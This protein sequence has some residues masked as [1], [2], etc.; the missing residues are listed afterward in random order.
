[1]KARILV[2]ENGAWNI[3]RDGIIKLPFTGNLCCFRSSLV[4]RLL[5]RHVL[6]LLLLKLLKYLIHLKLTLMVA[7]TTLK[8]KRH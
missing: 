2:I 5:I 8:S 6:M 7:A 1:M 3:I 4:I